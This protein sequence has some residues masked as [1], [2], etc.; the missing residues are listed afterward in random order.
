N[1]DVIYRHVLSHG[2][3]IRTIITHPKKPGKHPGFMFIQGYSPVSYD[4]TLE[5]STGDISTIDGPI[6]FEFA[7]SG[8]VTM[9]VE[10]PGVGD[11]EGGPFAELDFTTELDIYRQ[12]LKQLKE[13]SDVDSENVFIFG[14]SMGGAFGPMIAAENRVKGLVV[15]GVASRTWF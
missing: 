7:N 10:K 14:H 9:R 12:A 15:Y 3:K 6:L 11:S 2:K 5:G 13:L 8:F 4:F 1:Y